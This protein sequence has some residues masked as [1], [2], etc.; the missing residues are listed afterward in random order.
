M[1]DTPR[2]RLEKLHN[3]LKVASISVASGS[4]YTGTLDDRA[5][6]LAADLRALLSRPEVDREVIARIIEQTINIT[7]HSTDVKA[8]ASRGADAILSALGGG[9]APEHP[10]RMRRLP[11]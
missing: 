9:L 6:G 5:D 3:A 2:E 11:E 4:I 7:F 8:N 10:P 1:T